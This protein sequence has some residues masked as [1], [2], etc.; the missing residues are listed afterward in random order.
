MRNLLRSRRGS[1][2]FATVIALVP[3][4]GVVALGAEAGS[5]YVTRQHAQDAADSAAMAGA[6]TIA[7]QNANNPNIPDSHT[8]DYRG[9]EFAAQNTFCNSGDTTG[10]PGSNCATSHPKGI[11]QTVQIDRGTFVVATNTW[12]SSAGGSFVRATV[13]QQQPAYLAA[14][15]GLTTVNIGARAIAEVLEPQQ[16][17]ALALAKYPSNS[18]ALTL[19]GSVNF[20]GT[21][22][23]I[24]SDNTV[25]YAST[26]TFTGSGW[27]IDAVNGCVNSGNCNPGVPYN[28]TMLPATNPLQVLDTESFNTRTGNASA[29]TKLPNCLTSPPAPPGSTKCY[30]ASPNA[31]GAYGSLTVNNGDYVNFAPGT[32]FFYN[33]TIK[34]NGGNVTCT[35]CTSWTTGTGVGVTLVLL[36]NSSISITGG[37]VNL[38]ASKTNTTSSDLNGVLIDDQA[39]NGNNNAVK[40]NGSGN[41]ALGGAMYFPNVDVTWSGTTANANTTCSEVIANSLTMS[42]GANLSSQGCP[43]LTVSHTQVVALVR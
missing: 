43:P 10:Y 20:S 41:V 9:K 31:T 12:T 18:A 35:S 1:A 5:W 37:T 25:K 29:T 19:A 36:G 3:L 39:P 28:Y 6:M 13:R 27:S 24:A 42:G 22:C 8:Y 4:I 38:S 33:A 30:T 17:C 11:S 34:I 7:I 23:A 15:L 32:Y 16:I 40:I 14:V 26:P 2:A 21:G